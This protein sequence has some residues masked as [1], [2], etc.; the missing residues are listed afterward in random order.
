MNSLEKAAVKSNALSFEG[1]SLFIGIDVHLKKWV[2]TLRMSGN[3]L[4]TFAMNPSP[5][6]LIAHV[7]RHYPGASYHSVYEAGF[8]G[9]WIHEALSAA[10]FTS[11]IVHPCDVPITLK[12]RTY[13]DDQRDSRRLARELENGSIEGIYVPDKSIQQIRSLWRLRCALIGERTR[14]KNRIKSHLAFYG[15]PLPNTRSS[16]TKSFLQALEQIPFTDQAGRIYLQQCL[17]GLRSLHQRIGQLTKDL[18]LCVAQHDNDGVV[19]LLRSFPG[20]GPISALALYCEI[21]DVKRFSRFEKLC[22]YAGFVPSTYSSG[23]HEDSGRLTW[24]RNRFLRTILVEAAWV[25]VGRD[26][27]MTQAYV[28]LKQRMKPQQ[29]IMRIA[30]KLLRRIWTLW[31]RKQP[32]VYGVVG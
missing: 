9:F 12:E 20:I 24:R 27:A 2:V 17:A 21:I 29:A 31:Q 30:K 28:R 26:P 1:L 4:K 13:K 15:L 3:A 5:Q 7:R 25:A 32:Y 19:Q 14:Y 10:G 18:I 23:A 16:W 8:S 6:E 11:L 22:S